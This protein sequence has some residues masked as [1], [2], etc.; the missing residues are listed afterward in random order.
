M[1]ASEHMYSEL[2]EAGSMRGDFVQIDS[3]RLLQVVSFSPSFLA[4]SSLPVAQNK[5]LHLPCCL[6][7]W[8]HIFSRLLSSTWCSSLNELLTDGLSFEIPSAAHEEV[9]L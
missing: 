5:T 7:A 1:H 8:S 4:Q 2:Y 9:L 6:K 3:H